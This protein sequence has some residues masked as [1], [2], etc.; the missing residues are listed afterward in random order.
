MI[1]VPRVNTGATGSIGARLPRIGR[2]QFHGDAPTHFTISLGGGSPFK[3]AK[4]GLNPGLLKHI[5]GLAKGG[6]VKD[7]QSFDAGGIP[8]PELELTPEEK[9]K[10]AADAE[11]SS[12]QIP[13]DRMDP[14]QPISEM[15][16]DRLP[17][18]GPA[19][20]FVA[21]IPHNIAK[22]AEQFSLGSD[23]APNTVAAT[24]PAYAPSA[25]PFGVPS[26]L[27]TPLT[28]AQVA[29]NTPLALTPP[30]AEPTPAEIAQATK[31]AVS[32]AGAGLPR[33]PGLGAPRT[34][35][36]I[37]GVAEQKAALDTQADIAGEKAASEEWVR[38]QQAKAIAAKNTLFDD[39]LTK[40]KAQQ[41]NVLANM[42]DV[43]PNRYMKNLGS[44]KTFLA[45]IASALGAYGSAVTKA[46]NFA[47]EA[48]NNLVVRDINS[49][50]ANLGKQRS[51]LSH[52][53]E[54][55]H[56][57]Q[58]AR[59]MAI[60]TLD[61]KYS[62]DIARIGLNATS[63]IEKAKAAALKGMLDENAY[64]LTEELSDRRASRDVQRYMAQLAGAEA[65]YK[66]ELLRSEVAKNLGAANKKAVDPTAEAVEAALARGDAKI[67]PVLVNK[68]VPKEKRESVVQ[69]GP[70]L[71]S[72]AQSDDAAKK[73]RATVEAAD[74][75]THVVSRLREFEKNNKWGGT[76]GAQDVADVRSLVGNLIGSI[77][78]KAGTGA[79]MSKSEQEL[80]VDPQTVDPTQFFSLGS[81]NRGK[82][83]SLESEALYN[84]V[85]ARKDYLLR[86]AD[87][88][89][90]ITERKAGQ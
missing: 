60:A 64:K 36:A 49:Q 63:D 7:V 16:N 81:R 38:E 3:V 35:G 89:T 66:M 40:N 4:K 54:Q 75:M 71:Y 29:A 80:Q 28:P 10:L 77:R 13:G 21:N 83:N 70:G 34:I 32:A 52:F 17:V 22:G 90:E 27:T 33:L 88:T 19:I 2:W 51:L 76:P 78:K 46:P 37:P 9:A 42:K 74:M 20:N 79:A 24:G 69:T 48:I 73:Y 53:I 67:D 41:D 44:E 30:S 57:L 50:Q 58:S 12:G 65:P 85:A 82:L 62:D 61:R 11:A 43:D 68:Y 18:I 59:Q 25:G 87:P 14:N 56:D 8:H 55:G 72:Y 84:K 39:Q 86:P 6:E 15:L 45:V 1:G 23:E 5:Q 26:Q 47:A 31:S